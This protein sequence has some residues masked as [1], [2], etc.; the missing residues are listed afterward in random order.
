M[1]Q[2]IIYIDQ[3]LKHKKLNAHSLMHSLQGEIF[4]S[5][6]IR[7][8]VPSSLTSQVALGGKTGLQR[9]IREQ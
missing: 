7:F 9:L 4:S 2:E 8:F 6:R 1:Y 5:A 3:Q